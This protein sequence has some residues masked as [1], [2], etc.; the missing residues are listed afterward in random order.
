MFAGVFM[1]IFPEDGRKFSAKLTTQVNW[2][3]PFALLVGEL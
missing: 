3:F 2:S 1:P